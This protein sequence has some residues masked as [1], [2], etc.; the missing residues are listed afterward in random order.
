MPFQ[1]PTTRMP[2]G[3]TNA[4]PDQTFG[5]AGLP[6]PTWSH[7]FHNDFDNFAAA[8][9]TITKT[10]TGTVAL[11]A[12]D[13][14]QLLLTNTAGATDAIYMQP[15]VSTFKFVPGTD[16]FFKFAG[17]LTT[18]VFLNSFFAGLIAT[19]ATPLTAD[20]LYFGKAA[21]TANLMLVSISGGVTTSVSLPSNMV[22][23]ANIP[24]ELGFHVDVQGNVEAFFNP[25]TG[26]SFTP[27]FRGRVASLMAP[28]LTTSLVGP[29]FGLLN[30]S[31]LARGLG[32][33]YITVA[34]DR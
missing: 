2:N 11:A 20:G 3:V 21:A 25:G 27:G 22:L 10:G 31:A 19:S 28:G 18:D 32:V 9:W 15:A 6:D 29:S 26:S 14:G 13:G 17:V 33:D 4:S 1:A 8:D 23:T 12:V 16:T 34:R 24:F 30:A 7:V 5:A